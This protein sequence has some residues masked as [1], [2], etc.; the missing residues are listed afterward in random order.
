[1]AFI[2]ILIP[3]V[4]GILL[5]TSP[6]LFVKASSKQFHKTSK[7]LKTVGYVLIAVAALYALI[8]LLG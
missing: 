1:M 4:I 7:I 5:I 6:Q 2:D 3:L 8:K